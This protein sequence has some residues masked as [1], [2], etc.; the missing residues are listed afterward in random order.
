MPQFQKL[1]I[2]KDHKKYHFINNAKAETWRKALREKHCDF[3]VSF[4]VIRISII[5]GVLFFFN[6]M[7]IRS[8]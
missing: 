1:K 8:Q 7:E 5:I 6:R 2:T 3:V 4:T